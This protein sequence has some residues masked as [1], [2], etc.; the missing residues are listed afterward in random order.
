MKSNFI[1]ILLFLSCLSCE[2]QEYDNISAESSSG[3]VFILKSSFIDSNIIQQNSYD[4]PGFSYDKSLF[5]FDL[6]IDYYFLDNFEFLS[7]LMIPEFIDY[8]ANADNYDTDIKLDTNKQNYFISNKNAE[9][10]SPNYSN[11]ILMDPRSDANSMYFAK[12]GFFLQQYLDNSSNVEFGFFS[13]T[14]NKIEFVKDNEVMMNEFYIRSGNPEKNVNAPTPQVTANY[15]IDL[16]RK[17]IKKIEEAPPS[18]NPQLTILTYALVEKPLIDKN[19]IKDLIF[20]LKSKGITLN[21]VSLLPLDFLQP[22]VFE[23]SGFYQID[24]SYLSSVSDFISNHSELDDIVKTRVFGSSIAIQNMHQII[25]GQS[26]NFQRFTVS[27]ILTT[28]DSVIN[29]DSLL[30][31][32][33]FRLSWGNNTLNR[34]VPKDLSI[35]PLIN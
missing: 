24:I 29:I 12:T 15:F 14:T 19:M 5:F 3:Q 16:I 23:T 32:Q 11:L 25:S 30:K 22:I 21:I 27:S 7:G 1:V 4:G 31:K 13:Y 17:G 28:N 2:K 26:N 20:E 9:G 6:I 34:I 10:F 33:N 8:N 35:K 18:T